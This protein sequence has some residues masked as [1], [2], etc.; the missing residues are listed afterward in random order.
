MIF[1]EEVKSK[2]LQNS[3]QDQ[4]LLSNDANS[5]EIK[6]EPKVP[7][8]TYYENYLVYSK[9]DINLEL[10]KDF[11]YETRIQETKFGR[12]QTIYICKHDN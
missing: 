1:I 5:E 6:A 8:G 3:K 12:K 2:E 10:L 11:E 4:K 9:N 7:K